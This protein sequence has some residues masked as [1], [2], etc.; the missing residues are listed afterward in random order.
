[1][2]GTNKAVQKFI[3]RLK[4]INSPLLVALL[5]GCLVLDAVL[6]DNDDPVRRSLAVVQQPQSVHPQYQTLIPP[7]QI[8]FSVDERLNWQSQDGD[9][10]DNCK[11]ILLLMPYEHSI[12]GQGAQLNAYI[13]ASLL[14]TF[15]NKA[16]VILE[17]PN[18]HYLSE[19][20]KHPPATTL[21]DSGSQFGCPADAFQGDDISADFPRGLSR[22][23][24]NPIW[25]NRG[26]G[27]P[28][29][30]GKFGYYEWEAIR[31][32]QKS[33]VLQHGATHDVDCVEGDMHTT[34]TVLGI[35]SM[36]RMTRRAHMLTRMTD[37]SSESSRSAAYDWAIRL[38]AS[39]EEARV[40]SQINSPNQIW[41][42]LAALVNRSG[43]LRFQPWIARDVEEHIRS[44]NVPLDSPYDAIHVRRG[45]KLIAEAR[46]EVQ[47]YWST[48]GYNA[49]RMPTN[50]IPFSHYVEKVWGS[51]T[52]T[53]RRRMRMRDPPRNV[54]IATD[55]PTTVQSEIELFPKV[56]GKGA[57]IIDQCRHKVKFWFAPSTKDTSFH[58]N[59]RRSSDDCHQVYKRNIAAIADLVILSRADRFVGDYNS[60]WGRFIKI[61][62]SFLNDNHGTMQPLVS[63]WNMVVAFGP[64]HPGPPGT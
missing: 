60:N 54:Y 41:D 46:R 52:A 7:S 17:S 63:T 18:Y 24:Q 48:K 14:A 2:S 26:C 61:T 29:C 53:S 64:S 5:I 31:K 32:K 55:D 39:S 57:S 16:L 45:D 21:Y 11:D 37:R 36:N 50:Y 1:M 42:Y 27:V 19:W 38:G 44:L 43:L 15:L 3:E 25:V 12:N 59:D 40:F 8:D 33:Y 30:G 34:V 22:L 51:C 20:K 58:I 28:T 56:K 35:S 62:R 49:G 6:W 4:G 9:I 13:W 47:H 10:D 23:I